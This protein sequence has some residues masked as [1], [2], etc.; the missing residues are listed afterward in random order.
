MDWQ[1]ILGSAVGVAVLGVISKLYFDYLARKAG[2]GFG[3]AV[4]WLL[5]HSDERS[6][7]WITEGVAI[8]EEKIKDDIS[9]ESPV[10]KDTVT[11]MISKVPVAKNF[12]GFFVKTAVII[13]KAVDAKA[14]ELKK[15]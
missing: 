9:E 4:K 8:L 14:K 15:V 13:L 1:T 10:I 3:D 11:G 2:E 7:K 6:S 12:P 5:D